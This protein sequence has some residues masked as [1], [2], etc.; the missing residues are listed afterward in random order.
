MPLS[1]INPLDQYMLK[2]SV[3]DRA[4]VLG[5]LRLVLKAFAMKPAFSKFYIGITNHLETRLQDHR[6][7]KPDFQLMVPIYED[8]GLFVEDSFDRL[9]RDA[10]AEFRAGIM[11]P[12][13]RKMMLRC[14]NGPG[15]ARP[16]TVLYILVG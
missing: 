15:G 12:E 1:F 3:V 7:R 9:E 10:I 4:A 8:N 14:D 2:R 13:T 6:I 5:H 16:K 11:H